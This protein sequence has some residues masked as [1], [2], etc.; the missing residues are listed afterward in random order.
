MQHD[1]TGDVPADTINTVPVGH[2]LVALD[3]SSGAEIR[4]VAARQE[5]ANDAEWNINVGGNAIFSST[6]SVST[7]DNTET[8]TPDQNTAIAASGDAIEVD[9]TASSGTGGQLAVG[10]LLDDKTG[11]SQEG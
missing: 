2:I 7:S 5:G 1:Y 6:Q 10:V 4:R 11:K 3:F 8:F 9:V